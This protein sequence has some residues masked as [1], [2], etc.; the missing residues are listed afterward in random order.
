[1]NYYEILIFFF[2]GFFHFFVSKKIQITK[3]T[4][5]LIYGVIQDKN[6][7]NYVSFP[8]PY[9][10]SSTRRKNSFDASSGKAERR[11]KQK[12]TTG[13][14]RSIAPTMGRSSQQQQ[15]QV[16]WECVQ[17]LCCIRHHLTHFT[18]VNAF[19]S[20]TFSISLSAGKYLKLRR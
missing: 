8:P 10:L 2:P 12:P 18:G 4:F 3:Q 5:V 14:H 1:M 15:R 9:R 17:V 11:K 7:I 16:E 13:Q 6:L 19:R 20:P